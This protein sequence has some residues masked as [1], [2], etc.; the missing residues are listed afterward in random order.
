M[1]VRYK[2]KSVENFIVKDNDMFLIPGKVYEVIEITEKLKWYRIVDE[3]G[4]DYMY[5]PSLFD[6]IEE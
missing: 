2:G 3:S 4:E 6:I 5:P 1:K